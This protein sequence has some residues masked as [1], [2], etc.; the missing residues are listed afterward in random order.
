MSL[1]ELK[2]EVN[3][4]KSLS[5]SASAVLQ[6]NASLQDAQLK[7]PAP[8]P[9]VQSIRPN[10]KPEDAKQVP[11]TSV[12]ATREGGPAPADTAPR[13]ELLQWLATG[14]SQRQLLPNPKGDTD[15]DRARKGVRS[16][17]LLL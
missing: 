2:Q 17:T 4:A 7:L 13:P 3:A 16:E 1:A 9:T 6:T 5:T 12:P 10:L 14:V 15:L 8:S 11:E